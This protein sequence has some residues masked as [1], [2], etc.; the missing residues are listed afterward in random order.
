MMEADRLA[1]LRRNQSKLRVGKYKSLNENHNNNDGE[2][3]KQ[4][5]RVVLPSSYVGS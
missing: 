1:W 3:S 4:G 5:K 2:S